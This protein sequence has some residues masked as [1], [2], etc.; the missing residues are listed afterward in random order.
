MSRIFQFRNRPYVEPGL[1]RQL[2]TYCAAV[3]LLENEVVQEALRYYFAG[4]FD[5]NEP[6]TLVT[7]SR[8]HAAKLTE[9][10]PGSE[11]EPGAP[12]SAGEL[13]I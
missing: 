13:P 9:Q 5:D 7:I 1:R 6:A 10:E 3:G 2:E 12:D 8:K 4:L 11:Q